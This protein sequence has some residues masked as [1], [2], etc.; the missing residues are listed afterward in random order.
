MKKTQHEIRPG[1]KVTLFVKGTVVKRS[2]S[3]GLCF[4]VVLEQKDFVVPRKL[5]LNEDEVMWVRKP[6]SK[7]QMQ[8]R[9]YRLGTLVKV[10]NEEV[11]KDSF[12]SWSPSQVFEVTS[13][14]GM[15]GSGNR[16]VFL[17]HYSKGIQASEIRLTTPSER[18]AYRKENKQNA[19]NTVRRHS[20]QK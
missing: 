17:N 4:E 10:E 15:F 2:D 12:S 9:R 14:N 3:H 18:A 8:R 11:L 1:D 19:K 5:W 7:E 16:Y 13:D 6:I 20:V